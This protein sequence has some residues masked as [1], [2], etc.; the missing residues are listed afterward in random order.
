M[1][2]LEVTEE[3]LREIGVDWATLDEAV[4]N[5][6]RGFGLTQRT[7]L[8]TDQS[9]TPGGFRQRRLRRTGGGSVERKRRRRPDCRHPQGPGKRVF[10]QHPLDASDRDFESS[11]GQHRRAKIVVGEN[12]AFVVQS[13]I[14]ETTDF[15]TP[16][17]IQSY[18]Y[19]D[20]GITLEIT[21]HVSQGGLIR[22]NL[23]TEFTKLLEDVSA[24]SPETPTTAKRTAR[25][26][27]PRLS[28]AA[29]FVTTRRKCKRRSP[30]SVICRW[31]DRSFDHS[32]TCPRKRTCSSS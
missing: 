14:T 5:S 9:R 13:R 8:W 19:K 15:I 26:A 3:G 12:R 27:G 32:E 6:V 17:V 24:P 25:T 29:S 16:T 31:W 21:P 10:G 28:L 20:V 23:D 30:W 7:G 11:S 1:M 2:I 4:A 18:E 22:L